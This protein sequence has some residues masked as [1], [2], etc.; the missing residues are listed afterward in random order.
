[1]MTIY[2]KISEIQKGNQVAA[3]CTI[4]NTKGSTPRKTGAKMI[5]Y[6]DRKIFGTIGGGELERHVIEQAISVIESQEP[7]L[8][9]HDLLHQHNMCCGGTVDI[10]IEPIKMKNKLYIFGAG[11][12][13]KALSHYAKDLDFEVVLIDDRKEYLDQA[14]EVGVNKLNLSHEQALP[15]LPFD[16]QT[17]VCIVTYS[18]PIDREILAYCLKKPFAYLGMIGSE[19]KV[20]MTKKMFAEGLDMTAEELDKV[21]MPMGLDIQA[22]TPEEI[23]ISILSKLIEIKNKAIK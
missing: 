4:V 11:H 21:D 19:R 13:G 3:V 14:A 23:A 12:V 1:M 8:F 16:E 17:Y 7:N 6:N 5:V 22:E 2:E 10:F 15:I 9:R 18:H 20:A